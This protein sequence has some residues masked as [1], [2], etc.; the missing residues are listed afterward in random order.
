MGRN[1]RE[2]SGL[3]GKLKQGRRLAK[4]GPRYRYRQWTIVPNSKV[5]ASKDL[6]EAGCP[7][8]S[9][10]CPMSLLY[11]MRWFLE[12]SS[13]FTQLLST[14]VSTHLRTNTTASF[15][16]GKFG[17]DRYSSFIVEKKYS[18]EVRPNFGTRSACAPKYSASV[19]HC[20]GHVRCI[21]NIFHNRTM[22][23]S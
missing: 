18:A 21:S 8:S 17:D 10:Q 11:F 2:D 7:M 15:H 19:E 5:Q 13:V 14:E 20:K 16:L 6:K 12:V 9:V 4:A 23:D 1:G 22:S 3:K